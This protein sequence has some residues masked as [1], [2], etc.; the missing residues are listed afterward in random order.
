MCRKQ[1]GAAFATYTTVARSA[2]TLHDPESA[3]REYRSS[4]QVTRSF[5]GLCGSSLFWSDEGTP[6]EIEV[7]LGTLDGEPE[8][9]PVAHIFVASKAGWVEIRDGLARYEGAAPKSL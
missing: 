9:L 8:H 3:L 1:H 2:L 5:C 7:A 6:R 4:P